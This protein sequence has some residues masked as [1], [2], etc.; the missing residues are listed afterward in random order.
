MFTK[1]LPAIL[2][3]LLVFGCQQRQPKPQVGGYQPYEGY[4]AL[5]TAPSRSPSKSQ[6]SS[7]IPSGWMPQNS[8][9]KW[10]AIIIHHSGTQN[11]DASTFDS[12]HR[13]R[14]WEGIGYHFV[15]GNGSRSRNGEIEPTFRWTEQRTGAHT[16]GTPDNWANREA[17]GICLVGDFSKDRPSQQQMQSL[18]RL[19]RFLQQR[20]SIPTSR[21]YGH[22]TTPGANSTEC[23]G[24]NFPMQQF[25]A[26]LS[27]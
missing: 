25:K 3:L 26:M 20:Y 16:G 21:I 24:R 27:G 1:T 10:S 19:V 7:N 11:G 12:S 6:S 23:P 8:E 4:E 14:G 15:I 9:N 18:G 5:E 2:T 22:G 17:I 13:S